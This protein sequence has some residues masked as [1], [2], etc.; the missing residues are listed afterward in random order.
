M[1]IVLLVITSMLQKK[2]QK[3]KRENNADRNFNVIKN[4]HTMY[5]MK[6]LIVRVY[7]NAKGCPKLCV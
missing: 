6:V 4:S 1:N 2:G 7:V 5:V 3:K